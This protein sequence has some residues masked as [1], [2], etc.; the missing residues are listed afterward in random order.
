MTDSL[1]ARSRKEGKVLCYSC[2]NPSG[3]G[4]ADVLL[5]G[6]HPILVNV[7]SGGRKKPTYG[8]LT[9]GDINNQPFSRLKNN[10][11][12]LCITCHNVM[13]KSDEFARVWELTTAGADQRTYTLQKSWRLPMPMERTTMGKTVRSAIRTQAGS[14]DNA[15]T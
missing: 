15:W 1:R 3:V 12:L 8:N 6:G 10:N 2:H 13:T 11:K 7:T 5:K 4:H 14:R 9:G